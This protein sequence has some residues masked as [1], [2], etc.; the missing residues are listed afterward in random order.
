MKETYETFEEMYGKNCNRVYTYI[1]RTVGYDRFEAEDLLQEVFW[2]AYERWD[3]VREHPNIP[4]FLMLVAKHK[5]MKWKVKRRNLYIDDLEVLDVLTE[6]EDI[7][8]CYALAETMLSLK[9]VLSGEELDLLRYYYE[10]G[11]TANEISKKLGVTETCFK[12]RVA[13]MKE[14]VRKHLGVFLAIMIVYIAAAVRA[15]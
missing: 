8:N 6:K 10:Y 11:Y 1:C 7:K 5:L 2:V 4:A 15:L 9:S 14:K 3:Y 13:R 12:A